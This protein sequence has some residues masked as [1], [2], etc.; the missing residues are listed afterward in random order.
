MKQ[1]GIFNS[2]AGA[3]EFGLGKASSIQWNLTEAP[4]YEAAIARGEAQVVAGGPL[5]AETG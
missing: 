3:A 4:L 5:V 2:A 1:T